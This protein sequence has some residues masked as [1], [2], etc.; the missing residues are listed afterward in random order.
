MTL[1]LNFA[2]IIS[3]FPCSMDGVVIRTDCHNGSHLGPGWQG[4]ALVSL[5]AR[6]SAS[7]ASLWLCPFLPPAQ[8]SGLVIRQH[9]LEPDPSAPG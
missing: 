9:L 3:I 5:Q 7:W 2:E 1:G 4:A 8:G 6:S